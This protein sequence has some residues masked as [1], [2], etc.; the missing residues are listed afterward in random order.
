MGAE[1][2]AEFEKRTA[3]SDGF[4]DRV[5]EETGQPDE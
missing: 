5:A 2:Q 3:M 4:A 1:A